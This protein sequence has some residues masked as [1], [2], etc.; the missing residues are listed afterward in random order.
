MNAICGFILP[1]TMFMKSPEDAV[2]VHFAAPFYSTLL[3][4]DLDRYPDV[5]GDLADSWAVA[6]RQ[7]LEQWV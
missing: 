3:K 5:T 1:E 2:T 7:I 6:L 4:F